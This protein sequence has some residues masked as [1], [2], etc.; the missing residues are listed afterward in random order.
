MENVT[1]PL[2]AL[3]QIEDGLRLAANILESRSR[4]TAAD[5]QIEYSERLV[6]WC[7]NQ[8]GEIPSY[9]PKNK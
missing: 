1:V 4:E 6:K 8:D 5:R 9:L 3:K 2:Y 7:I